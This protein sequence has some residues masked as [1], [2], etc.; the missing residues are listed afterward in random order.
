MW[1]KPVQ[2]LDGYYINFAGVVDEGDPSH[3]WFELSGWASPCYSLSETGNPYCKA[4]TDQIGCGLPGPGI[5]SPKS[6]KRLIQPAGLGASGA[7]EAV[8]IPPAGVTC[9]GGEY[10]IPW[11]Y[12]Q[13]ASWDAMSPE[14]DSGPSP[15]TD[16]R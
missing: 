10:N 15:S 3:L 1:G 6:G 9:C 12:T 11:S 16:T 2:I 7:I 14:G 8:Q 4:L 5:T 13:R